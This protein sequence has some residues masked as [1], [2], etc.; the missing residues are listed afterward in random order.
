M[1]LVKVLQV[2][3]N[4][5]NGGAQEVVR[6]LVENLAAK[7]CLPVVCAFKDGPVRHDIEQLGIDVEVIDLPRRGVVAL[8]LFV[9]DMARICLAL[10]ELIRK[11]D[12]DIVQTHLSGSIN[13]LTL[14]LPYI[15]N[16]RAVLWTFH[17]VNFLPSES[18]V[19]R[20]HWLVKPKRYVHR[21]MYR[22]SS[23]RVCGFIAVSN[24]VRESMI[25][26]IGPVQDKIT[27][28]CNG[29]DVARYQHPVD[30]DRVRQQLGFNSEARLLIT[31]GTLKREKGH[32]YLLEAATE[33]VRRHPDVYF[34]FVGDGK[35][36]S[37]L[38]TQTDAYGLSGKARFLGTRQDVDQLL[39]A[40]D[41][42]VLPSLWEGMSMALL[43]AMAA[44]KPIVATAVSG[45]RQVVIHDE[46][47]LLVPPGDT[48][49][50]TQAVVTLLSEPARARAM[51]EAARRRV[52]THFSME[53]QAAEYLALYG[54][55]MEDRDRMAAEVN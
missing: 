39:A 8:P 19:S 48:S 16:L 13:F 18:K 17:S 54:H 34:L 46:T 12:I 21:L 55:V 36:R 3:S 47:G 4:L 27:V 26:K 49:A 52:K 37:E 32:R 7:N 44:A 28:I 45:T 31:V 10:A 25:K 51:G 29:V 14:I 43:E 5:E 30:R 11:Y 24:Q 38:Q 23:Q 22:V 15:T 41:I 50:L 35:L 9:I 33:I 6:T 53:K 2:I 20:F 40:S 42:F 1:E